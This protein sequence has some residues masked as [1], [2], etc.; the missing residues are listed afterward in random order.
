VCLYAML[1]GKY[2]F[3]YDMTAHQV[4]YDLLYKRTQETAW[5]ETLP[6]PVEQLLRGLL[7]PGAKPP[8]HRTNSRRPW[9][10]VDWDELAFNNNN[11]LVLHQQQLQQ[12][13]AAMDPADRIHDMMN[14]ALNAVIQ[15]GAA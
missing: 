12:A 9:F 8:H 14:T 7:A 6:E 5:A 11:Q 1:T 15:Q 2:P 13:D 4:D 10:R 3:S